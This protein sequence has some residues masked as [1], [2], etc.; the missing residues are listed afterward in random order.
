MIKSAIVNM[1]ETCGKQQETCGKHAKTHQR[2]AYQ[3]FQ[4]LFH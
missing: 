2:F 1:Q 4:N 3:Y